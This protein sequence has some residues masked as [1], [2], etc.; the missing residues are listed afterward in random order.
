MSTAPVARR[1]TGVLAAFRVNFTVTP[2]GITTV[3]ALNTPLG[4]S[5]TVTVQGVGVH[6]GLNGPSAPVL[7]LLKVCAAAGVP[8]RMTRAT[9]RRRP[10]RDRG[11]CRVIGCPPC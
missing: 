3:V 8:A 4:G 10:P 2:W 5:G 1:I 9:A 6:V 11:L 7:P